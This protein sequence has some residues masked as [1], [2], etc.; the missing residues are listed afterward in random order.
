[1]RNPFSSLTLPDM[2]C[3]IRVR[4]SEKITTRDEDGE[5]MMMSRTDESPLTIRDSDNN[6]EGKGL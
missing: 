1:M 2:T 6:S 5:E 4:E 3:R